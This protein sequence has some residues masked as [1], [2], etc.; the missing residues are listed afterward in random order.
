MTQFS[1]YSIKCA[2]G[3][4]VDLDLFE[5][6]NVT[7]HAEL[8]TRINTRSINSYKC[9]KCGAESELA[10]HFLYVDM[11]K[12]YWI[13]VFPEGERE[14]KAQIEEQFIESN[15]LSK[16]LPKLHQSQLIIV[17]GYDELFEILAN[18]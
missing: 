9:G 1:S 17:F 3:N 2:C 7:V 15:E 14:N 10:Y 12:G 18:N 16:Q 11:E 4:I 8:I 5:S 6:V 13:W